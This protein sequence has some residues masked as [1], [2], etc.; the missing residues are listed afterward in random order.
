M[1]VSQGSNRGFTQSL[2]AVDSPPLAT[3]EPLIIYPGVLPAGF[4]V[5]VIGDVRIDVV[6]RVRTRRFAQLTYN[7][8]EAG[9]VAIMVGGTAM[10]FARAAAPHFGQ[11]RVI[12]AIGDDQWSDIIWRAA[13]E[14]GLLAYFGQQPGVPN[15]LVM[16][17]RDAGT[18]ENP[19]GVRLMLAQKPSP[20][21]HLD[22]QLIRG[23]RD[24][25]A[26]S[27]AL[28]IDG[29]ALLHDCSAAAV[30]VATEIAMDAGVPVSFD[31]VPHTI[32]EQVPAWRIETFLDLAS[33]RIAEAPTLARLLG[34]PPS[35]EP[36]PG[37]AAEL[38]ERLP[39][40]HERSAQTSFV[41]YGY[42]MME[43]TVAVERGQPSVHY[44]T[45]YARQA[46]GSGYGYRVA[47]A[48]LKW[49]LTTHANQQIATPLTWQ[50]K[51]IPVHSKGGRIHN[52]SS[53]SILRSISSG[54]GRPGLRFWRCRE[55]PTIRR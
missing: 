49:W 28:V 55:P 47:A 27:D 16:I 24:V 38:V 36:S 53:G 50:P 26:N 39:G 43:E 46:D 5:T 20:Y 45:G 2:L 18:P 33:I 21:D 9:E 8:D 51:P 10:S 31:V 29:Y 23:Q 52:P 48:E 41:R 17:V 12:A 40:G 4:S 30:D 11:V 6:S 19:G 1:T 54:G 7:H 25:I 34:L 22:V 44:H 3:P 42:G 14:L 35:P 15:G 13:G 32:D 37:Y